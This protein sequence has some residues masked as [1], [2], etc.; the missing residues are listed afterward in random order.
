MPPLFCIPCAILSLFPYL[1]KSFRRVK[2]V[3]LMLSVF[4]GL[5]TLQV[6]CEKSRFSLNSR[7]KR[8]SGGTTLNRVSAGKKI[9]VRIP[10]SPKPQVYPSLAKGL[11]M[12]CS[13]C[14]GLSFHME[15][16]SIQP[17]NQGIVFE[18]NKL[19]FEPRNHQAYFA[20]PPFVPGSHIS[21]SKMGINMV[22]T[23]KYLQ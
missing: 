13:S 19:E 7:Q 15:S 18:A 10:Q 20:R 2:R 16:Y 12:S 11:W 1:K 9:G 5:C 17:Y 8:H 23:P 6:E 22:L 3:D 21:I 14:A 4:P